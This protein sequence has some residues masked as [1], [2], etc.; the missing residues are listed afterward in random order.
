[1]QEIY[2]ITGKTGTVETGT[3]WVVHAFLDENLA[4]SQVD[5]LNTIAIGES[6]F[7]TRPNVMLDLIQGQL[8]QAAQPLRFHDDPCARV[9]PAGV[10]YSYQPVALLKGLHPFWLRWTESYRS[11]L[12]ESCV[13]ACNCLDY[14]LDSGGAYRKLRRQLPHEQGCDAGQQLVKNGGSFRSRQPPCLC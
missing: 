5:G 8:I 11:G 1:M 14:Q 2:V 4:Q 7:R 13:I 9:D 10:G 3:L 6:A 12:A